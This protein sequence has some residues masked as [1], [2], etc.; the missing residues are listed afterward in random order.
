MIEMLRKKEQLPCV[1]FTFSKR[2]IEENIYQLRSVDLTTAAE[3]SEI[4]IFVQRCITKLK[5]PDRKLPQVWK[6]YLK[7]EAISYGKA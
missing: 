5:P 2:K 3:K 1:T 4:H 7:I 6:I